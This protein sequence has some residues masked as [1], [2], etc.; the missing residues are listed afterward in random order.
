MDDIA[1]HGWKAF[2]GGAGHLLIQPRSVSLDALGRIYIVDPPFRGIV[3]IDDMDGNGWV[4]PPPAPGGDYFNGAKTLAFDAQGRFYVS[5]TDHYRIVRFDDMNLTGWTTFGAAG[6]GVGQFNRPEGL[7]LDSSGRIYITDNENHRVVR[8]N[9]MTGAGMDG[10]FGTG[11]TGSGMNEVFEPHDVAISG[12]GKI[13]ISDTGNG[14][15]VRIDDMSGAGWTAFGQQPNGVNDGPGQFQ[16]TAPKGHRLAAP[17]P[18]LACSSTL[19][20]SVASPADAGGAGTVNVTIPPTCAWSATSAEA[21]LT[22]FWPAAV[23]WVMAPSITPSVPIPARRGSGRSRLRGACSPSLRARPHR[24]SLR[25]RRTRSVLL[26]LDAQFDRLA[27]GIPAG[28][29]SS[30]KSRSM[31][32]RRGRTCLRQ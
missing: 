32:G 10:T 18:A 29:G 24:F 4:T 31:A 6:G 5:D 7:A 21:W 14:R 27:S 1:G 12:S 13:Y 28:R 15:V 25:S 2:D 17:I 9:D 16:F 30:G 23:D 20:T 22:I 8:I 11:T 26:G 19:S 3:R